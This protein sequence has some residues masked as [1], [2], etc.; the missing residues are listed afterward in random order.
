MNVLLKQGIIFSR[1][2]IRREI[3]GI[4]RE[5]VVN[6]KLRV[7][8]VRRKILKVGVEAT[9]N[10]YRIEINRRGRDVRRRSLEFSSCS[11]LS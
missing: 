4:L 2:S 10:Q 3:I 5:F 6:G 11:R 1:F 7:A 9:H 8:L